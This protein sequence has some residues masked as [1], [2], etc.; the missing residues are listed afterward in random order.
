MYN[1]YRIS[2]YNFCLK[3]F[4]TRSLTVLGTHWLIVYLK[5]T[6]KFVMLPIYG[7]KTDLS[8]LSLV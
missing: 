7:R 5:I 8:S 6:F 3:Y 4:L 2:G 1:V